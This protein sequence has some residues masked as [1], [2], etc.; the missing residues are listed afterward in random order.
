MTFQG[1]FF[2]T[3]KLDSQGELYFQ[4]FKTSKETEDLTFCAGPLSGDLSV[5]KE[6]VQR[7]KK[8]TE[9]L[10]EYVNC[11]K[12]SIKN[13]NVTDFFSGMSNFFLIYF[14][15]FHNGNKTCTYLQHDEFAL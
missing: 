9:D 10:H 1:V 5:E 15:N 7:G 12:K 13:V 2:Y 14:G 11:C 4:E 3:I 8:W 6:L